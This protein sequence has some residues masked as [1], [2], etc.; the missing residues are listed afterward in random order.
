MMYNF[1]DFTIMKKTKKKE[2]T[3]S[4]FKRQNE[5]EDIR[6]IKDFV[7]YIYEKIRIICRHFK[8]KNNDTNNKAKNYIIDDKELEK[9]L[10]ENKHKN[11]NQNNEE[12][13]NDGDNHNKNKYISNLNSE[14][15]NL[16]IE[17]K[18][19]I[20]KENQ[21]IKKDALNTDKRKK[22]IIDDYENKKL[23]VKD[24]NY[25]H[26]KFIENYE[27][28]GRDIRFESNNDREL[29]MQHYLNKYQSQF[30]YF[31]LYFSF[32]ITTIVTIL[33]SN[34]SPWVYDF[35]EIIGE[36]LKKSDGITFTMNDI[37]K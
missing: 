36:G 12:R 24:L 7:N 26:A 35:R 19:I 33:L 4:D 34:F 11:K 30:K 16:A 21:I 25:I 22:N 14:E 28:I 3:L 8:K 1:D 15:E 32:I 31:L 13:E 17:M 6:S 23:S 9:I 27:M 5:N 2:L 20:D 10:K 37:R 29:L 18:P